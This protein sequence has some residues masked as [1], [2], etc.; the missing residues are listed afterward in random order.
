MLEAF[1][2]GRSKGQI[3][4]DW[5]SEMISKNSE[6]F[7]T[8]LA[9]QLQAL[10]DLASVDRT[11]KGGLSSIISSESHLFTSYHQTTSGTK[12]KVGSYQP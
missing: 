1:A 3:T 12:N 8:M 6:T 10:Q 9:S 4:D 2:A 5:V 7:Q 11:F